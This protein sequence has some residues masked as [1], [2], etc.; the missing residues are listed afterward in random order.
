MKSISSLRKLKKSDVSQSE[1]RKLMPTRSVGRHNRGAITA[2]QREQQAAICGMNGGAALRIWQISL[3]RVRV[4]YC[5][6]V[7]KERGRAPATGV[8]ESEIQI[9]RH[10]SLSLRTRCSS[11]QPLFTIQYRTVEAYSCYSAIDF[12][13]PTIRLKYKLLYQD[14]II[15]HYWALRVQY[16]VICAVSWLGC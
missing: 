7:M 10:L 11:A 1:R 12:I 2:G 8:T 4:L 16:C 15:D 5:T 14:L 9:N 6:V 3:L 13:V